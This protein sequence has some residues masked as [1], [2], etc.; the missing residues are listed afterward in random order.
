M[1]LWQTKK[2]WEMLELSRQVDKL[3]YIDDFL[4]EKRKVAM[5]EYGFFILWVD[6]KIENKTIEKIID[7]A[8]KQKVLFVQI[9]TLDY[10]TPLSNSLPKGERI[11]TKKINNKNFI[12]WYYKKFITPYTAL[13]DLEKTTDEMLANMKPKWRYNIRLSEK[14]WVVAKVYQKTEKNIK[15]FYYLMKE[16]T[17]RDWFFWNNLEYYKTFLKTLDNSKLILAEIDGKII[18]WGIFIFDKQVSIYYY[19]AST[20]E[21]KY[22][23][24]MAPYAVQW[25]AIKY[26]KKYPSKLYDFLWIASPDEKNSSLAWV[27]DFKLKLTKETKKVS[28][29][30]IFINK[31]FKYKII[32]FLRRLKK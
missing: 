20:S 28:E 17:S 21:K 14:K 16:T 13:I 26:A 24:L 30:F 12:N 23:N 9:E 18:A 15:S 31:K 3:F 19:W 6:K 4:I 2:W 29:S 22:R 8:K 5:W 7:L 10:K 32:Q 1:S 27:T 11:A 25:E